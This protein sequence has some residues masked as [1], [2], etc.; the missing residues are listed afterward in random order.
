MNNEH[1]NSGPDTG[2]YPH[3]EK[4]GGRPSGTGPC[5]GSAS[6]QYA[7]TPPTPVAPPTMDPKRG[8]YRPDPTA[9]K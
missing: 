7:N 1:G 2:T 8:Y 4:I 6:Q 5:K 9:K 3:A